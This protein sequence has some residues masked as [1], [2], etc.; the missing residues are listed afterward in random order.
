MY[1]SFICETHSYV[2]LIHVY[3]SFACVTCLIHMY[4]MT[5]SYVLHNSHRAKDTCNRSEFG[6]RD[7]RRQKKRFRYTHWRSHC[8]TLAQSLQHIATHCNT[9]RARKR[10]EQQAKTRAVSVLSG[11]LTAT[12]CNT[13]QH[14]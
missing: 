2:R 8:N 13:L 7:S 12:H 5:H 6:Y 9:L 1:D 3:D 11:S 14:T 10:D 4:D